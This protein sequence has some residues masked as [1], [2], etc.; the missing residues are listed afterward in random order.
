MT[1]LNN[2]TKLTSYTT[3]P[4]KGVQAEMRERIRD[5]R[6]AKGHLIPSRRALADEFSI[7]VPTIQ[8]AIA[9]MV[10]EGALRVE[11][12]R[13]TFVTMDGP[14]TTGVAEFVAETSEAHESPSKG[15]RTIDIGIVGQVQP[16]NDDNIS[17]EWYI[18][19]IQEIEHVI[20]RNGW[21]TRYY[22]WWQLSNRYSTS[23]KVFEAILDDNA[24]GLIVVMPPISDEQ[25]RSFL[26]AGCSRNVPIVLV[27]PPGSW[28]ECCS[29]SIDQQNAGYLAARFLISAGRDALTFF[30]PFTSPWV[31]GRIEGAREACRYAGLPESSLQVHV[32]P[33]DVLSLIKSSHTGSHYPFALEAAREL[34]SSGLLGTG[35]IAVNDMTA[36]GFMTAA[37]EHGWENE[38]D[39]SLLGFDDS[40][41]AR[42]LGLPSV[43]LPL[44]ELGRAAAIAILAAMNGESMPARIQLASSVVVRS[45]ANIPDS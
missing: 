12:N 45:R 18:P 14:A 7:S 39:Y 41:L 32:G 16:G 9:D 11:P 21:R 5:G 3:P 8:R 26:R 15:A 29:V 1:R 28:P 38:I 43:R 17:D 25:I 37:R 13:G 20:S 2:K 19:I 6:W 42:K 35:V 24:N 22:D 4:Y 10:A 23:D 30:A 34:L 36:A 40:P 27:E 33:E 44:K 31:E